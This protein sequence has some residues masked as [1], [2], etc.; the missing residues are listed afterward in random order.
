MIS[1]GFTLLFLPLYCATGS[2]N[3]SQFETGDCTH[4]DLFQLYSQVCIFYN[5]RTKCACT[6][7]SQYYAARVQRIG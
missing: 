1:L 5:S 3:E 7:R 6:F 2:V 4:F